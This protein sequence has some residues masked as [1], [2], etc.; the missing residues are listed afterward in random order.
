MEPE[1]KEQAAQDF[2]TSAAELFDE[3]PKR[4]FKVIG[5]LPVSKKKIRIQ[6]LSEGELSS[7]QAVAVGKDGF[8]PSRMEDA[9]RRLIARCMVDHEG[10]RL[11]T[12]AQAGKLAQW[13]SADTTYLYNECATHL[14]LRRDDVEE[15]VKNFEAT[16][17][18]GLLTA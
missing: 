6:S 7:Y 5:P 2:V 9:N 17:G 1:R 16:P 12:D 14:G 15:A 13:D 11:L 18:G 8:R 10:N 3:S 4:R